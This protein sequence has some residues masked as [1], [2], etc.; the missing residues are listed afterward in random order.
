MAYTCVNLIQE[1][2]EE[3]SIYTVDIGQNQMWAAQT[4]QLNAK[5]RFYTS[6]G[7]APMGYALHSAIGAAFASP[8]KHVFCITGDGGFHIALQS[9]M[10][11]SQYNL[12]IT[13]CILNNSALGMITQFQE[14]Y[15]NSNMVGTTPESGYLVPDISSIA[16]AYNLSYKQIT[17]DSLMNEKIQFSKYQIVEFK[18]PSRTKVSPKL[19]YNQPLYNMNPY[20]SDSE[21]N[22]L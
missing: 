8:E 3:T 11:I 19:E 22:E 18:L 16:K 14:L 2:A 4:L 9:L 12:N 1:Q 5:Q 13:V 20:L 17:H 6:G 15:F 10:L 21:I 7:L